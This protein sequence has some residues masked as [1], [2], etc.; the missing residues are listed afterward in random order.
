MTPRRNDP[1][2]TQTEVA[3]A[4]SWL[5]QFAAEFRDEIPRRIHE[6]VHGNVYGLGSSPPFSPEF[7]RYIGR[8]TCLSPTCRECRSGEK[9]TPQPRL[10]SN[11]HERARTA[12]AFR[13]L[14]KASPV[15]FDVVFMAVM[16]HETIETITAKLNERAAARDLTDR[17][18]IQ[19]VNILAMAGIDKL[20]TWW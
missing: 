19:D 4:Q 18:T 10:G 7:I 9:G 11:T 20:R 2:F 1:L 12:K 17:Y 6:S 5:G 14:R 13:K 3:Q 16:H 8:L 15:E